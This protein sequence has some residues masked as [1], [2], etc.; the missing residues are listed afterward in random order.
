MLEERSA[1]A[2]IYRS[3]ED[4]PVFL[5]LNYPSGHWDFVKGKVEEGETDRQ[6]AAREAREETGIDDLA[7]ME[8]FEQTIEYDFQHEGTPV[9]KQVVFF[10]AETGAQSIRLSDEHTG[11][12]WMGFEGAMRRVTFDN[13]RSVLTSARNHL[14]RASS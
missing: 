12:T 7:F 11:Y 13:A 3:G 5:L 1:G 6:T 2:I 9:H 8:G 10:L 4:G 14:S